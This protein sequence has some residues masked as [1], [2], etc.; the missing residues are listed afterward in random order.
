MARSLKV[1]TMSGQGF[2]FQ[3]LPDSGAMP[4]WLSR[5]V[6]ET[7]ELEMKATLKMITVMDG[8]I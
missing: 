4:N 2:R 7:P 8:H 5:D 6:M 1:V 3:A